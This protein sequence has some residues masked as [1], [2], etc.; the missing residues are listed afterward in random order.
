M[1]AGGSFYPYSCKPED[2]WESRKLDRET[3]FFS[4][5]QVRG[6]YP[7]YALKEMKRKG[8]VLNVEDEDLELLK[9]HTVDFISFS[10]YT[11]RVASASDDVEKTAGNVLDAVKNPYLEESEWGWQVDPLGLRITLN[12]L[13]DRYQKPLFI[14]ENGLGAIDQVDE[15]GYV[16]DTYRIDYLAKHI[17]AMKDAVEEDGVELLGY[18]TWGCIDLVS[19]GSGQMKKRYGFIYVDLDDKGAGTLKRTKKESFNWYKQVIASNGEDL[20]FNQ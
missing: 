8:V 13:Y 5:V 20:S 14:V 7:S 2:V 1:L 3:Y 17:K 15:N 11:S 4:D 16:N 12:D 6:K 9:N 19:A 18:T 10:Y